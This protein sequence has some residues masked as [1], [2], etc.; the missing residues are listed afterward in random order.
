[1][2]RFFNTTTS[3]DASPPW[4]ADHANNFEML[5]GTHQIGD[6]PF[7]AHKYK[8]IMINVPM[9]LKYLLNRTTALGARTIKTALPTS[10][11]LA[12]TLYHAAEAVKYGGLN[13]KGPIHAFV[14]ATGISARQLVPDDSV[15][16][17]RGQTVTVRGEAMGITTV[18]ATPDNPSP[19]SPNITYILPRPHSGTTILGGTKQVGNWSGEPDA[20]TT[21]EIVER[22]KEF[23]P[24]LLDEK[25]EFE[26]VSV[27]VGLRP[28]RKGGARVEVEE[29]GLPGQVGGEKFAVCHAYG[30]GGAGY[31]NSIGS[32]RKVV[33][34]LGKYFESGVTKAKL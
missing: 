25:G 4:F 29:V 2:Y 28:G 20:Q 1:L 13:N 19:A 33:G 17:V 11:S 15:F 23:A 26:V 14:N 16:P 32:A 30:H 6:K 5:P 7:T 34:L 21:K 3:E 24:E 8:S 31:Q 22:A 9:Y 27:Q 18:D 12:G 10:T